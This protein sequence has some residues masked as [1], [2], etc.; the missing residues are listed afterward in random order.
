VLRGPVEPGH[1]IEHGFVRWSFETE[2][3]L[4]LGQLHK[5]ARRLPGNIYRAQGVVYGA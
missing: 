1:G 3:S 2:V 5:A 4:S